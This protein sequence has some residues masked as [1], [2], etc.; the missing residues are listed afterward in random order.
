MFKI[1]VTPR[2]GDTDALRHVNNNVLGDWFEL[3]RNDL[4]FSHL[5]C[6]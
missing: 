1:K 6:S 5:I 4:N 2:F 3:G